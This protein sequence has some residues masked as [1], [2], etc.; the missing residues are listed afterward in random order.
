M[1]EQA[2]KVVKKLTKEDK[3]RL[4]RQIDHCLLMAIKFNETG[5]AEYYVKMKNYCQTFL[6]ILDE[7]EKKADS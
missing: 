6:Q 1:F 4:R 3:K 5:K 2:E 7:L